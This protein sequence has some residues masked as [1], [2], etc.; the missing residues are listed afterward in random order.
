MKI[1]KYIIVL[2][3]VWIGFVCAISF[4][5]A[6]VKFQAPGITTSLGL[7]VGQVVFRALNRVEVFFSFQI[8]VLNI[9]YKKNR[10]RFIKD[11][12]FIP[13]IILVIQTLWLLPALHI[14]ANIIITGNNLPESNLHFWYVILELIKVVFLFAYGIKSLVKIDVK[15]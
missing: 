15:K 5:E 14:R 10:L 8:I 1:N 9:L 11:F 3:F 12:I 6:W 4:M 2:T 13:V 7:S